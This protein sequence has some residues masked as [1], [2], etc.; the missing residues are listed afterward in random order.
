MVSILPGVGAADLERG[1]GTGVKVRFPCVRGDAVTRRV[2]PDRSHRGQTQTVR[3]ES[4]YAGRA[5]VVRDQG[6]LGAMEE[7]GGTRKAPLRPERITGLVGAVKAR[8]TGAPDGTGPAARSLRSG[9]PGERKCPREHGTVIALSSS[10]CG[11][12]TEPEPERVGNL[13]DGDEARVAVG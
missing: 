7:N 3:S 2:I 13:D 6:A 8:S 12:K 5:V 4:P 11:L 1:V 10:G 9:P